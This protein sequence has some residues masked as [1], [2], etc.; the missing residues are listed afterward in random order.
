MTRRTSPDG[1]TRPMSL[2]PIETSPG[3][4]RA[5]K[6]KPEPMRAAI[7]ATIKQLRTDS[8]HP[9]LHTHKVQGA[10]GVWEAYVDGAN[11]LTFHWEGDTIVLR[12]HCNH[13]VLKHP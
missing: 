13:D 4:R 5:Y 7:K 3:F 9:G 12:N 11:R 8:R 6:R 2:T 10:I 1:S